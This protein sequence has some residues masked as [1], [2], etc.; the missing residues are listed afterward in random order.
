MT[1]L[2]YALAINP[3]VDKKVTHAFQTECRVSCLASQDVRADSPLY[4]PWLHQVHE[5]LKQMRWASSEEVT[6][7]F[8][9]L[10][11]LHRSVLSGT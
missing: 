5:E 9:F 6:L 4:R 3:D 11:S 8:G 7:P 2:L 10:E 1:W